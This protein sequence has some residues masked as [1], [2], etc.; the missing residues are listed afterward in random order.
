MSGPGGRQGVQLDGRYWPIPAVPRTADG[1]IDMRALL[2]QMDAEANG[3]LAAVS[4]PA[5]PD[6]QTPAVIVEHG[7]AL[8]RFIDHEIMVLGASGDAGDLIEL[9]R[10]VDHVA[11]ELNRRINILTAKASQA[12]DA[13][14][15]EP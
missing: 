6:D 7:H 8:T 3:I 1:T 2:A 10:A 9:G 4:P 13:E 5:V 14:D 15:S 12:I 11:R